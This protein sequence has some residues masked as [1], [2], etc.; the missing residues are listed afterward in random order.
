MIPGKKKKTQYH[1][2][3]IKEDEEKLRENDKCV[4]LKN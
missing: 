2:F 1:P 3:S 4:S